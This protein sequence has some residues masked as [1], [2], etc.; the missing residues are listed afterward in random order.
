M[1]MEVLGQDDPGPEPSNDHRVFSNRQ[2]LVIL[3]VGWALSTAGLW[4]LTGWDIGVW[5]RAAALLIGGYLVTA[6]V[7]LGINQFVRHVYR[8]YSHLRP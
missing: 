6:I 8:E 7:L 4:Q 2:T 1:D 3:L 5:W